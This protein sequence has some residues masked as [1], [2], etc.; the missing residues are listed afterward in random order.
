LEDNVEVHVIFADMVSGVIDSEELQ[1]LIQAKKIIA[2]RR[3]DDWVRTEAVQVRGM[4][5]EIY[6]GPER[7]IKISV[8]A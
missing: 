2:F 3:G 7:R 6:S 1:E 8:L 5:G 4:G